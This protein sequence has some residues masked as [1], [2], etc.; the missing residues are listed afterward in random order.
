MSDS[1]LFQVNLEARNVFGNTPLIQAVRYDRIAVLQGLLDLGADPNT[2]HSFERTAMHVAAFLGRDTACRL[3]VEAKAQVNAVDCFDLTP[4]GLALIARSSVRVVRRLLKAGAD[5]NFRSKSSLPLLSLAVLATTRHREL[6][7]IKFL[8]RAGA[9][10]RATDRVKGDTALHKAAM[11]G[12][13]PAISLLHD[14]GAEL[15]R[16]NLFGETALNVA[17]RFGNSYAARYLLH[18]EDE[19]EEQELRQLGIFL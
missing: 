7:N 18:L 6:V 9:D 4:L 12:F 1:L 15:S 11:T 2:A 5:P 14:N 13:V 16:P 17:I 19:E 3:L 8:L 10:I